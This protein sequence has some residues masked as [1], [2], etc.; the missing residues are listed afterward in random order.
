MALAGY[1]IPWK[2]RDD[3][4]NDKSTLKPGCGLKCP[5]YARIIHLP[6]L[7][8]PYNAARQVDDATGQ[9]TT[10]GRA[11]T[12][13]GTAGSKALAG[14]VPGM[15][16]MVV[17]V[18]C[19][20]WLRTTVNYQYR[21]GTNT[22][23]SLRTLYSQGGFP[24]FY[25]GVSFALIQAPLARFGDTAANAGMLAILDSSESSRTL[26]L[27]LKTV[28]ASAAAGAFRI[29]LLPIDT[30]KAMLQVEGANGLSLLRAKLQR[31]GVG[32]LYHGSGAAVAATFISHYPWFATYNY[33][34]AWLPQRT[35]RAP[36]LIR[37]A[38]IGFA[39]AAVSDVISNPARVIKLMRQTSP[40]GTPYATIV[41]DI[42]RTDGVLGM[43]TRGLPTKLAANGVQ[44]VAFSVLWRLG[45]DAWAQNVQAQ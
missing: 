14:G 13:L 32:V 17:Q 44:S 25:R 4:K 11:R 26:P 15:A 23:T 18:M 12:I 10:P 1:S 28:A 45:Q 19:L 16:A 42:V 22:I 30:C 35:E 8:V 43:A 29:F 34:D 20:M 38:A 3:L 5:G 41:R 40:R 2:L 37:S 33:L 36:R 39:A 7:E 27:A 9:A 6:F 21:Y 24:R 31:D